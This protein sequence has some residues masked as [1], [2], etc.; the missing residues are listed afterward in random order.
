[1]RPRAHRSYAGRG[2]TGGVGAQ[3]GYPGAAQGDGRVHPGP[4]WRPAHEHGC[5]CTTQGDPAYVWA[6]RPL[7]RRRAI[8]D[9]AHVS[10]RGGLKPC[11]LRLPPSTARD[12]DVLFRARVTFDYAATAEDELSLAKVG[13]GRTASSRSRSARAAVAD[14]GRLSGM[15]MLAPLAPRTTLCWSRAA[16]TMPA[17]GK[18]CSSPRAAAACSPT[19]S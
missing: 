12:P 16:S 5:A 8:F 10:E 6:A 3:P 9:A 4:G 19:T 17:G 2:R 18:A 15:R 13:T 7:P 11:A 14:C 1:M